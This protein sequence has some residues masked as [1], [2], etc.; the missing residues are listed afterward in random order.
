MSAMRSVPRPLASLFDRDEGA[1]EEPEGLKGA[2]L[3]DGEADSEHLPEEFKSILG[4]T[5][6]ATHNGHLPDAITVEL[7][8]SEAPVPAEP[9]DWSFSALFETHSRGGE[10]AG[11]ADAV[12]QMGFCGCP[13][14]AGN[15]LGGQGQKGAFEAAP[16]G[17][18]LAGGSDRQ[19]VVPGEIPGDTSTTVVLN[20]GEGW[21]GSQLETSGDRDW[22]RVDL[23]AGE[24]YSIRMVGT[25]L[26]RLTDPLLRLISPDGVTQVA[27]NDDVQVGY[28]GAA[29]SFGLNSHIRYTAATTGTHFIEARAFTTQ[30]G[31]YVVLADQLPA[32]PVPWTSISWGGRTFENDIKVYFAASGESYDGQTSLGWEQWQIDQTMLSL[33]EFSTF[34]NLTFTQTSNASEAY[35]KLVTINNNSAPYSAYFNPPG[36]TAGQGVGVWNLASVSFLNASYSDQWNPGSSA[37]H[38]LIHEFGH[39][40]GLSHTHDRGGLSNVMQNVTASTG[41]FGS[42]DLNQGPFTMMGYNYQYTTRPEGNSGSSFYGANNT[43]GTLDVGLLQRLYGANTNHNGGDT[44]YDIPTSNTGNVGYTTIWDTG[45]TDTIR[46]LGSDN[47]IIDLRAATLLYEE[48]GGGRVSY[49]DGIHGGFVIA[50]GVVI[51]NATGGTGNDTIIGNDADNRLDGGGGVNEMAG[52]IGDDTYIVRNSSDI[53]I[54]NDGEGYDTV[55][56]AVSYALG[57]GVYVEELRTTSNGSTAAINLTGNAFS[58]KIVGNAGNNRLDGGGGANVLQGLQGDDTYIVRNASDQVIEAANQ[59]YDTVRSTV[60]YTLASGVHVEELRTTSNGGTAAIRLTGNAFNQKIVGNAGD[61]RLD[62]GGGV[63]VLQGLGGNDTYFVRNTADQVIEK[64]NEGYDI[65]RSTVNYTLA[66][67]VHVEEL[68]TDT[69]AGT[70]A[71]RLTGNEFNQ[72]IVGNAGDNRLDGGG[73]V[74]VLEGRGGNDT[75]FIRNSADQVIEKANEGYDIVRATVDYALAA[76]THIEE[77]RTD[78]NTGTDAINLTGNSF[79]QKIVGNAGNNRLDGGGGVNVLQGNAGNDTYLVR[80][81]ADQ[82]IEKANEG[83]DVVR[84]TVS[85]ALAA[86]VH[87]EELRTNGNGGTAAINLTGNGF[88]QKIVGNA[89]DN[90]IDGGGG[91]NTLTGGAGMDTFVFSTAIGA[92]VADVITDFLAAD[93]TIRLSSAIFTGLAAGQ[94]AASRFKDIATGTVDSSDRILYNSNTGALFFD[95]DGSGSTYEPVQFAILE[96]KA[97]ITAADFFVV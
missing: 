7:T 75:Y 47:A 96:N 22:I 23:V 93:D 32:A 73:G 25:G 33:Q 74:N 80:N 36:Y 84:A 19:G 46:F 89:G 54:E 57:A 8:E 55:R 18:W 6:P 71:L 9:L 21:I 95:R 39:A 72:K 17:D 90:V 10:I 76:G 13:A 87:V 31:Q 3:L 34:T 69:N 50:N 85:Y 78:G 30:T 4:E 83:Y 27:A 37:W 38:T 24:T 12:A 42:F 59:G 63:N 92:A 60:N 1:V 43:P 35:F 29:S 67:G 41:S 68:R 45:G 26:D 53:V 61:N 91:Q 66:G 49:A 11:G 40:L 58:Q 79:D 65:V 48:G 97:A 28:D 20:V 86:N 51:E 56:A 44:I 81:A 15:G 14:C 70:T 62:G 94:L 88:A 77:L 52:G 64:A 2:D 16:A 82:V 5:A